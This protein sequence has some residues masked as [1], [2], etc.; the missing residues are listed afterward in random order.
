MAKE[1][2]MQTTVKSAFHHEQTQVP[3]TIIDALQ[4]KDGEK[5][6]WQIMP[7]GFI[8]VRT[9]NRQISNIKGVLPKPTDVISLD[10]IMPC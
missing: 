5:I 4:L 10:N 6:I 9:K 3:K 7:D 2:R 1:N 8:T